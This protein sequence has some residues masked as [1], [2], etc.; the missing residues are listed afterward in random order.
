MFHVIMLIVGDSKDKQKECAQAQVD[1]R[2]TVTSQTEP[3]NE[4]DTITP[5]SELDLL[6]QMYEDVRR[7]NAQLKEKASLQKPEGGKRFRK[8]PYIPVTFLS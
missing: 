2:P 8:P 1:S 5:P 6:R 4:L 3:Q 7:E